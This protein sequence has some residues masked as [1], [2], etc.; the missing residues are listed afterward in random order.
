MKSLLA[1]CMTALLGTGAFAQSTAQ[2]ANPQVPMGAPLNRPQPVSPLPAAAPQPMT[3]TAPMVQPVSPAPAGTSP[4]ADAARG[5]SSKPATT[6]RK[7]RK[8]T[9]AAA[10]DTSF[11]P[12]AAGSTKKVAK[13]KKTR[14]HAKA[15][16]AGAD[17]T[18][19]AKPAHSGKTAKKKALP[20]DG[21][22]P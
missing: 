5:D 17:S 21:S 18:A 16:A 11:E 2:T 19:P 3:Q 1:V 22:R 9:V 4:L 10:S 7:A 6:K 20:N 8:S 14:K 12:K 13:K 15:D